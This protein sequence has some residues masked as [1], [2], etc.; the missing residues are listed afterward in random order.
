MRR[1][2]QHQIHQFTTS[3]PPTMRRRVAR[4]RRSR[5]I[6][7]P[8]LTPEVKNLAPG[9]NRSVALAARSASFACS[10]T[11]SCSQSSGR[12]TEISMVRRRRRKAAGSG[13]GTWET[14]S[15]LI[16]RAHLSPSSC[17][18]R[19]T[20][21]RKNT[22]SQRP[23]PDHDQRPDNR[24][25]LAGFLIHRMSNPVREPNP[26]HTQNAS[27][28]ASNSYHS[29]GPISGAFSTG[30]RPEFSGPGSAWDFGTPALSRTSGAKGPGGYG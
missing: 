14:S 24:T 27:I 19:G 4:R 28:A 3:E 10:I 16:Y 23:E 29:D 26:T 5:R 20:P 1:Y 21:G 25:S 17:E 8:T 30:E 12:V 11:P 7:G 18:T 6:T 22:P 2:L 15:D 13:G 9:I